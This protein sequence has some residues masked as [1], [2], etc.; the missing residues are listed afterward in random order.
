MTEL[1][2]QASTTQDSFSILVVAG[3]TSGEQH[4]AGLLDQ[5]GHCRPHWRLQ[6]FGS[7]GS[8]MA[9]TGVELLLDVS[10]LAA[11]GPSAAVS[12]MGQYWGLYHNLLTQVRVR[13]PKLALLVDFPEFNLFLAR[14]LKPMGVPVCYFIGP[15]VWAWRSSRLKLIQRYVDLMLV[16]FPFEVDYYRRHGVPVHYVGNPSMTLR[17]PMASSAG[18]EQTKAKGPV[19]ALLPGS[20]HKEVEHIFP[21][22]LDAASYVADRLETQFWV[23]QAPDISR[24]QIKHLYESWLARGNPP[25]KLE[26]LQQDVR[27]L[28]PLVDCAII[29]S[30]TSTL[31]ATILQVPFAMVYRMSTLSWHLTRFWVNT[32]TYCL[33]NLIAG[34]K[35]VPE[36]V[37]AEATGQKIGTYV[38]SLLQ[39]LELRTEVKKNLKSVS[40][41]LG[42]LD[43]YQ[44]A[45]RYLAQLLENGS[46]K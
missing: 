6:C 13:K 22:Q 27:C 44:Q 9:T 40:E 39:N 28:L 7:G 19:V 24:A 35:I 42:N 3:E 16:I 18:L 30:G 32:D 20:R 14:R 10:Q 41:R 36:F 5:V 43:A 11:I 25:L 2:S 8:R 45:A 31:E 17:K 12:H 23:I 29:K 38:L 4:A 46:R 15:Q 1:S 26:I 33:A 37:Q 21:I 34:R